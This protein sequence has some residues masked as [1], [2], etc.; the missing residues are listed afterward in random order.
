MTAVRE[1]LSSA[2][3]CQLAVVLLALCACAASPIATGSPSAKGGPASDTRQPSPSPGAKG[4]S[5]SPIPG[6]PDPLVACGARPSGGPM[7]LIGGAL[8][9][10]T[11]P[12]HPV[13]L[14]QISNT[15]AHLFTGDTITYIRR[16]GEGTEAVLRSLGSGNEQVVA[17]WPLK[18]LT[19]PTVLAGDWAADG[20]HAANMAVVTEPSGDLTVQVSLFVTPS[21]TMLYSFPQPLTDCICRFGLP[22]PVLAF[23]AD[24]QYLVS[25]WPIGKG[26]TPLRVYRV[27][28]AAL[29][30]TMDFTESQAV[31]S[32]TGHR[33]YL[34][35]RDVLTP[36]TW[37]PEDGFAALPGANP[38]THGLSL[39][40]D[41]KQMAYTAFADPANFANVSIYVYDF[42]S[43]KTTK[44]IDKPRSEI[45][46]VKDGWVWY[47]EEAPCTNCASP[48]GPTKKVFAMNLGTR[49]ETPVT[50]AAGKSPSELNLQWSPAEFW[51][52][53]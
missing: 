37:S 12:V 52:N 43:Q 40:P 7:V 47:S 11:D 6:V 25:G 23:S 35:P 27:A 29:V 53:S 10:V 15:T 30:Q 26:A 38:W 20:D 16:S 51:P 41:G 48:T 18:M 21:T 13:L 19:Q 36:R 22:Y 49:I 45:T 24:G 34:A 50:F 8:Y 46:F 32:R 42:A 4:G 3:L 31:W 14:C 17:G 44:V 39:S 1:G 5:P 28:D 9:E 2:R 33:L